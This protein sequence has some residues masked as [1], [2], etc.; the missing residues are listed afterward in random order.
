MPKVRSSIRSVSR[1]GH[2]HG[3][4]ITDR[5]RERLALM[6]RWYSVSVGHLFRAENDPAIWSPALASSQTD[7]ARDLVRR[8]THSIYHRLNRLRSI[9]SDPGR[10]IG[11]MVDNDMSPDGKTAWFTTRIGARNAELP[12]T[13]RNSI[14]PNFASHS[15]MAADIGMAIEAAGYRVLSEREISTRID[16]H[17]F[18]LTAQFESRYEAPNG[19]AMNKKP[20]VAILAPNGTDYI[21]VEAERDTDRSISVYEQ[22]LSAYASNSSVRAVWY[23]CASKTTAKRVADGARKAFKSPGVFPLRIM[24]IPNINGH[25][26]FDMDKLTDRVK[27]DLELM[28]EKAEADA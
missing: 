1:T 11:P 9:E 6:G 5:D 4:R 19:R 15:W 14:N 28:R 3:V 18:D 27:G 26:F 16:R 10:N 13:M 25:H 7:E 22:K 20:D 24:T 23:I 2:S 12:W 8:G 17:G 21:A